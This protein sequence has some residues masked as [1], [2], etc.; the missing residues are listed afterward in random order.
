L[1]ALPEDISG[2]LLHEAALSERIREEGKTTKA[3]RKKKAEKN[4][5]KRWFGF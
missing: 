3:K 5:K 4:E 2:E 1:S